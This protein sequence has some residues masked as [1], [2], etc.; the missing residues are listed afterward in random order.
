MLK[1]KSNIYMKNLMNNLTSFICSSFICD[2][3]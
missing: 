3:L 1:Y 2:F